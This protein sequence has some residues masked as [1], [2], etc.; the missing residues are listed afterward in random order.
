VQGKVADA[1]QT[2]VAAHPRSTHGRRLAWSTRTQSG[3][4][5]PAKIGPDAGRWGSAAG[6]SLANSFLWPQ[7]D[8]D[9]GRPVLSTQNHPVRGYGVIHIRA[10]PLGGLFTSTLRA[11]CSLSDQRYSRK[12]QLD[13]YEFH[14]RD[15]FFERPRVNLVLDGTSRRTKAMK[16]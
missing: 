8:C 16:T 10:H 6:A 5:T 14:W 12:R 15:G 11:N 9:A 4:E 2:F 13:P 3:S 7:L 1:G